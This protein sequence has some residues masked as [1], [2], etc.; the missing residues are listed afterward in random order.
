MGLGVAERSRAVRA[1]VAWR[2]A[3]VGFPR[4]WSCQG[5]G[6]GS[7]VPLCTVS[8]G[9]VGLYRVFVQLPELLGAGCIEIS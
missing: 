8:G 4:G 9:V 7:G 3:V 6:L 2:M 5:L 1:R